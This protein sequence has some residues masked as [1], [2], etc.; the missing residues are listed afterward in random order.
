MNFEWPELL[1]LL[2]LVPAAASA[3]WLAVRRRRGR[4]VQLPGLL[5]AIGRDAG[6]GR[7]LRTW[8][9]VLLLGAAL[10]ALL[11]AFARPSAVLTLPAPHDT[12]ILAID[13]SGSMRA[14]DVEPD[15]IS[16]ARAAARD[17]VE[18]QPARTR[19]G[20]VAFAAAAAQVQ[21]PTHDRRAILAALDRLQLQQAT[22]IG[23]GLLVAL[24]AIEPSLP[25]DLRGVDPR[26][27]PRGDPQ[28]WPEPVEPGSNGSAAIVLLSDG[29]S[30]TGPDPLVAARLV[31]ERGVRVHTVGLGTPAGAVLS[32]QG[33]SMRVR[34]DEETLRKIADQ[35]RGDYYAAA[36]A[37]E[38]ERVYRTLGLRL[39]FER[40]RMEVTSLF[41]GAGALLLALSAGL[42]L[43]WFRRVF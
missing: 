13:I 19:I 35:T 12:V 40:Q 20:V 2:A 31:A 22:A 14:A 5:A 42:S 24:K 6:A 43:W 16:A 34:L 8:L 28:R 7:R 36:D 38:L 37:G 1:W 9:P 41:A 11:T 33:W 4:M 39:A 3:W 10:V 25:I 21:A 32:V 17:F 23:S 27:D 18:R 30:V 26:G 15:R 29:Q